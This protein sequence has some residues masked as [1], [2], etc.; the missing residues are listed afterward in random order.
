[1][2]RGIDNRIN[3]QKVWMTKNEAHVLHFS[4]KIFT[5]FLV[6]KSLWRFVVD[7]WTFISKYCCAFARNRNVL[8][9][10]FLYLLCVSVCMHVLHSGRVA[11][12]HMWDLVLSS[13]DGGPRDGTEV[14]DLA[15]GALPAALSC[16]W[17]G[18][19]YIGTVLLSTAINIT[20]LSNMNLNFHL[21][22]SIGNW[23]QY[24]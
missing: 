15:A 7:R 10:L 14:S 22:P 21:L 20:I 11:E 12:D 1:M 3:D 4:L 18:T 24:W 8:V 17:L 9:L 13:H 19:S 16:L 2:K 5:I 23:R 6:Q